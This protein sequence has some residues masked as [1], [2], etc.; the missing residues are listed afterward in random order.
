MHRHRFAA[1]GGF[2]PVPIFEDVYLVRAMARFGRVV[3]LAL[4]LPTSPR[5]CQREGLWR[6]TLRH[7]LLLLLGLLGTPPERLARL[8]YG[9][10]AP[11]LNRS[12]AGVEGEG[13]SG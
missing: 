8:R 3:A 5:R 7:Q 11:P 13:T 4:P 2:R 1:V 6:T 12:P 10:G 9:D